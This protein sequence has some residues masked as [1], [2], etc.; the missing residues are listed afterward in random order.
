MGLELNRNTVRDWLLIHSLGNWNLTDTV[1]GDCSWR[2]LQK[3][4]QPLSQIFFQAISTRRQETLTTHTQLESDVFERLG[5]TSFTQLV[6]RSQGMHSEEQLNDNL[7]GALVWSR[8]D[9]RQIRFLR[10]FFT[11]MWRDPVS[12]CILSTIYFLWWNF[13]HIMSQWNFHQRRR[14]TL[15]QPN[16]ASSNWIK[17]KQVV[18]QCHGCHLQNFDAGRRLTD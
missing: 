16:I 14:A 8:A 15:N 7:K 3:E 4:W 5:R 1:W 13:D 9:K 18:S 12:P 17:N 6:W 10:Y 2:R 11:E